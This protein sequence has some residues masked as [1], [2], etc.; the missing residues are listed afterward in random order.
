VAAK[1]F[2]GASL[3]PCHFSTEP[4]FD[5][6]EGKDVLVVDFS[7]KTLEIFKKISTKAKSVTLLDHHKS[8]EEL[9]TP[10]I[11]ELSTSKEILLSNGNK[12]FVDLDDYDKVS[13]YSWSETKH[14]G[15]IAHIDGGLTY[16]HRM[17]FT[18]P[19][20]LL[21]DHK[22]RNPLDNRKS[23]LRAATKKQNAANM[24]RISGLKGVKKNGDKWVSQI[25]PDGTN[26]YLGTFNSQEDA[27]RAYDKAA[28]EYFGEFARCNFIDS[29]EPFPATTKIVFDSSRSGAG[30]AWDYLFGKDSGLPN[31]N[32]EKR[33]DGSPR[34][35][36]VNYVED[37]DIWKKAL[38]Y[39]EEVNAYLHSLPHTIET[40]DELHRWTDVEDV[41]PI[42]SGMVR[43]IK[44]NAA[45]LVGA[46][47]PGKG[48]GCT[49]GLVNAPSFQAS[50]VGEELAKIYDIGVIW[51]ERQDGVVTF[52]LRSKQPGDI[53]V[54]KIATK[55]GGGGHKH[56]AGFE[57]KDLIAAYEI[58]KDIKSGH[59]A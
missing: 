59:E 49:V 46:A 30:L 35:F 40:W 6:V 45:K 12:S 36:Y 25:Q 39:T 18:P 27:A 20:G 37:Y 54:S 10:I 8:A 33:K 53:D 19:D 23:N 22:N 11:K 26:V 3:V 31:I 15:A 43:Q 4:P 57:V 52:S 38:P 32:G 42:G 7:W 5:L 58:I 51:W 24:V 21:I 56:A 41:V 17:I 44:S 2:P 55:M 13:R 29:D 14:G 50:E 1:K 28:I 34:P 9:L 47:N 48:W 16:M